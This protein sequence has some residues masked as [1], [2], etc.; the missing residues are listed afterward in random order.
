VQT[1]FLL[2][3]SGEITI[4]QPIAAQLTKEDKEWIE[5]PLTDEESF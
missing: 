5:A 1:E 4:V 3:D 2:P